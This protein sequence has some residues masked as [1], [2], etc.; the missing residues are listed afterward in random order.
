MNKITLKQQISESI[1]LFEIENP[2]IAKSSRAGNFVIVRIEDRG[3]RM[4]LAIADADEKKGMIT[5]VVQ[6]AGKT[7]VKMCELNEGDR[8]TDVLGPL[9]N[10]TRIEKFGTVICAGNGIGIA[11]MLPLIKA[12]KAH[13]NKVLSVMTGINKDV[14]VFEDK[15]KELSDELIILTEDGSHGDKGTITEGMEKL[16]TNKKI[17]KAFV[18]ASPEM[19]K[20]CCELT[21]KYD[22]PTNVALYTT[23]VD[24][25]GMCGSCRITIDG[26]IRFACID[27]P[28]FDGAKI[29]WNEISIRTGRAEQ[30]KKINP[31]SAPPAN[32]NKETLSEV[33]MD[34]QP[35]DDS[36]ET[37]LDRESQWRKDLRAS[38]KPK[39]RM[40]IERT[41]MPVLNP[42][43][44]ITT[45]MEEVNKGFTKEM[46][47]IEAK[48]CLDCA[49][50]T[51][52]EGCPA[53]N[54]IPAF[55]KN[56]ER[57]QFL[58][59]AKVLKTT[60]SLPA[61]CGR[62]CPQENQCEGSCIH[63]KMKH[64]AVAIGSLE[65]FVADYERESGNMSKPYMKPAN[66]IK[67]A[68]VGSGPAGLSFANDMAIN[69]YEIH[70][71]E[72]LHELG[73]VLKY[74]IPEF[75][76]PNNIVDVEIENLRSMGVYFHTD[77]MI[78]KT[79]TVEELKE[80]GF[81]GIF[82]GTG[83]GVPNFMNIPGETSQNIMSANEFLI[84]VNLMDADKP[85]TD[86]PLKFAKHVIVVGGGNTAMDSCCT[87]RRLGAEVTLVYRRS[88]EEMPACMDERKHAKEEGIK[89]LTLHNPLEYI[90]DENGAVKA[91]VLQEMRLGEPDSSGRRRPEP[92]PDK[93]KTLET[94]MVI[95][96]VGVSANPPKHIEGLELSKWDTI[97]VND[98]MQSSRSDIYAGGDIVRGGATVILAMGDGK[99]AAANMDKQLTSA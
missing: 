37:L 50:P 95:V 5:L 99:R 2:Q 42:E 25:A 75:R 3:E 19:M 69:G 23:M 57:G 59:A 7:S 84:R 11:P 22:I 94:D 30:V 31:N 74:G 61:V 43:Y 72:S 1:Y 63:V 10:P 58:A 62:V 24:G 53:N 4:P 12:L 16:I 21:S 44:R 71:F 41:P 17:D 39:E 83:A 34:V 38:M 73:G 85:D 33:I 55:I 46:A 65:R 97:V 79:I 36:I 18:I 70:V 15:I 91:V 88:E 35:T 54:N 81:K 96:A 64:P 89:F 32:D 26:K 52:V 66:G 27:G 48:R 8:L 28:D 56:I 90:T 98:D 68:V 92:I 76:L 45:R 78:G 9:G 60:T 82:I 40:A 87:A 47:M 14:I 6:K 49:K 13:G 29:D 80:R 67:I 20:Q 93:T 51:C 86:T 77:C